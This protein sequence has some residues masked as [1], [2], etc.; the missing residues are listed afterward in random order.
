MEIEDGLEDL[1]D[2]E[3]DTS[4]A[5][6]DGGSDAGVAEVE[7]KAAM[8]KHNYNLRHRRVVPDAVVEHTLVKDNENSS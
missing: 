8:V 3:V 1:S 6:S 4:E 2:C 5:E 7:P